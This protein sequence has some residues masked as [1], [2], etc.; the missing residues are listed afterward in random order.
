MLEVLSLS[1]GEKLGGE[2]VKALRIEEEGIVPAHSFDFGVTRIFSGALQ[3][4]ND[5]SVLPRRVEPVSGKSDDECA[6]FDI[7][8]NLVERFMLGKIEPI[9]RLR[10]VEVRIGIE[11]IKEFV[12][13]M[14]QITFNRERDFTQKLAGRDASAGQVD[15]RIPARFHR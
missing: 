13:L 4:E 3:C 1:S 5:F 9:C 14:V 12:A 10:D 6:R 2:F 11:A 15:T 8:K 7:G